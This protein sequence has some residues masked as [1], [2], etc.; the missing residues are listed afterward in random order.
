[1]LNNKIQEIMITH[2]LISWGHYLSGTLLAIIVYYGWLAVKFYRK[3]IT[4]FFKRSSSE[5]NGVL[6]IPFPGETTGQPTA[7]TDE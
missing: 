4:A 7:D 5:R 6:E 3:D 2:P 1:L